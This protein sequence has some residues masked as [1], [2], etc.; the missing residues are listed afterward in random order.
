MVTVDDEQ[1]WIDQAKAGDSSAYRMLVERHQDA[2][3]RLVSRLLGADHP[4][5]DDVIQDVFV[6]AY[7]ALDRFRGQ[8]AFRTWLTRIAVNR[9]R[10]EQRRTQ[11]RWTLTRTLAQQAALEQETAVEPQGDGLEETPDAIG[12][13]VQNAVASLPEK[14]RV[15]VTLKDLEG[16]S[17]EE[18]SRILE[19]KLGTVKSRHARAREQLRR[20]LE[21]I[22]PS[23][24]P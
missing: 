3:A 9:C 24:H 17:Y 16:Y 21:P 5:I 20:R 15:V 8:A 4:G 1:I 14:L 12:Q 11:R 6:R 7:F 18:V 22:V 2:I 13:H 23:L 19:C 10:D